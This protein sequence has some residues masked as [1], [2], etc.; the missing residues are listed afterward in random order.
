M[1]ETTVP[2][3]SGTPKRIAGKRF[4]IY[5]YG[6]TG[7]ALAD[8]LLEHGGQVVILDDAARAHFDP[9]MLA[10][11]ESRGIELV[12]KPT[13]HDW[14]R[15][16]PHVGALLPS[17]GITLTA[18]L[19]DIADQCH[20]TVMSELDLAADYFPGEI[21]GVTGTN[22]KST[23]TAWIHHVLSASGMDSRIGGNFGTP[24]VATLQDATHDTWAVWELSSYQ[25]QLARRLAPRIGVLATLTP[26]H[27]LRHGTMEAYA[28]AKM[29]L[30]AHQRPE[31]V[32]IYNLDDPAVV[33]VMATR[34]PVEGLHSLGYSL[35]S[36][37]G[38]AGVHDGQLWVR[39]AT[40]VA[41]LGAADD[42][43]I[44]G[45][46]NIGNA[47]ATSLA[48]LG[49][50]ISLDQLRAT[51]FTFPGL[52]HRIERVPSTDERTWINDSKSTNPESTLA[53]LA[54]VD[55]KFVLILGGA[56]KELDY[57]AVFEAF[58][59]HTPNAVV[60]MGPAGERIA[61]ELDK[62]DTGL[63]VIRA[64][65]LGDAVDAARGLTESGQTI[66]FSPGA[67]SFNEFRNFEERG[68][69]FRGLVT[70]PATIQAE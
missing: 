51:L 25:L 41:Y 55:G 1:S 30:F 23:I 45:P 31:D 50:G 62:M 15:L 14:M 49:A 44:P 65:R 17:P 24:A 3:Q 69:K 66:L 8:F 2:R 19:L 40:G 4:A 63:R 11:A 64:G 48:C 47:L 42:L 57:T 28:A 21:I 37:Q 59:K 29:R 54:S 7:Q 6:V 10:E 38:A 53:A 60:T 70:S 32:A 26:D 67:P 34:R 39:G 36:D 68:A 13:A 52:P 18:L 9:A 56:E 43:P 12:F 35:T 22:G 46:H 5:G 58:G 27:L 33:A 16:L 20:V 61:Q